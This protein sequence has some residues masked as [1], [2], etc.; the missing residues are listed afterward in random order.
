MCKTQPNS[1]KEPVEEEAEAE[2]E[3]EAAEHR[4]SYLQQRLAP[5]HSDWSRCSWWNYQSL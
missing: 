3:V 2:E 5:H 1:V 4:W